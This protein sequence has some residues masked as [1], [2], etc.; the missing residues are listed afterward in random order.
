MNTNSIL[1]YSIYTILLFSIL[2][3]L[4]IEP[5]HEFIWFVSLFAVFI[6]MILK[7]LDILFPHLHIHTI[8][9]LRKELGIL[10]AVIVIAFAILRFTKI[11]IVMSLTTYFSPSNF[12][13]VLFFAHLGELLAVVLVSTSNS[14][15]KKTLGVY[16][17]KIQKL[18]YLYF[19]SG[20]IYVYFG[21]GK[22]Y[23]L[24]FLVVFIQYTLF[25]FIKKRFLDD[26]TNIKENT[27]KKSRRN[28]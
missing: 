21:L 4:F 26:N 6:L 17:F 14:F 13:G 15:A 1:S 18:S 23:G 10:S 28:Q 12:M 27:Q 22:L 7:P 5:L 2:S 24:L 19:L 11:G 3:I 20:A 25:S 9:P 8:M 16:W